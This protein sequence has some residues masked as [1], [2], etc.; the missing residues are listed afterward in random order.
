MGTSLGDGGGALLLVDSLEELVVLLLVS[1]L[2]GVTSGLLVDL[3]A[4]AAESD[5]GDETLDLGGNGAV[6]LSFLS[7]D[8]TAD[9][10][11]TDIV[12]LGQVEELADAGSTLG[13]KALGNSLISNAGDFGLSLLNNNNVDDGHLGGDDA[14]TDG[15]SAAIS[16]AAV[17]VVTVGS[18]QKKADAVG[19]Q[20]SL[21]HGET[22]LIESSSDTE[23]VSLVLVS[24]EVSRDILTDALIVEG[25]VSALLIDFEHLGG[26]SGGVGDVDLCV[27]IIE[28][29]KIMLAS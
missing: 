17:G 20:D 6:T 3:L 21:L 12:V 18:V 14:S 9:D 22:L 29:F 23:D 8:G 2:L 24:Q 11:L 13:A 7:G 10:E 28:G 15:L 16:L 1:D 4:A 25:A 5:G 26:T 27:W 19:S